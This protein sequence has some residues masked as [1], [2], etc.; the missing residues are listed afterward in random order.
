MISEM[1][2]KNWKELLPMFQ[3]Q[4][5]EFIP[6]FKVEEFNQSLKIIQDIE[7][8]NEK[9]VVAT[10]PYVK[11]WYD[12]IYG[13]N[14]YNPDYGVYDDEMYLASSLMCYYHYTRGNLKI[15]DKN[16]N[17]F[18]RDT[19]HQ[20]IDYGC[21]IGYS[22][23]ALS[24]LFPE[25]MVWGTNYK[26]SMQYEFIDNMALEQENFE[27]IDDF[28]KIGKIDIGFAAEYFEHFEN[29]IGHLIEILDSNKPRVM[30]T[31][32]SFSAYAVGHFNIYP[33][34]GKEGKRGPAET[35]RGFNKVLRERG[36]TKYSNWWNGRPAIW[37]KD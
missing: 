8:S 29:P 35:T 4:A 1:L 18:S 31:A 19:I 13:E 11:R 3:R 7:Y 30:V 36:Y 22:S 24:E 12:S 5:H 2:T 20:I 17:L 33:V 32:N 9:D 23:I 14:G 21:G 27:A 28:K 25:A 26:P 16:T 6:G 37:V 15:L 34:P 10:S